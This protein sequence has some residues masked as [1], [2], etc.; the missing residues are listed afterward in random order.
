MLLSKKTRFYTILL[1]LLAIVGLHLEAQNTRTIQ[2]DASTIDSSKY[3][4]VKAITFE[5][6]KKNQTRF[7][8]SRT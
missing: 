4:I 5:G 1:I 8:S 6:N 2:K 3:I 7:Y